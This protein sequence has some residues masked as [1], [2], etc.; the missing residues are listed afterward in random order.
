MII[1]EENCIGKE[2]ALEEKCILSGI[3]SK[4]ALSKFIKY[5]L[6]KL[7]RRRANE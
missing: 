4:S 2:N 1:G 7:E 6:L 5:I 3:Q